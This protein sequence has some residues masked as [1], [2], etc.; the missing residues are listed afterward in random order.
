MKRSIKNLCIGLQLFA[1][2]GCASFGSDGDLP[3]KQGSH[4]VLVGAYKIDVGDQVSVSVWKNPELSISEPVR[5]DGKIA[6]HLLGDIDAAGKTPEELA[7][8]IEVGLS[9]YIMD[10]NVT[11]ILT[12]LAGQAFLSRIRVTGAV[13]SNTSMTYHQG[14]TVLDAVLDAGSVSIYADANRTKLHRRT[15][16]GTETYNIRLKDILENG[17]MTTNVDL[18]PGD[19]IT[20][21]ESIF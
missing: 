19:V 12:G 13:G 5:P 11:V 9:N 14:M 17:D 18:A 15:E 21:P 20:V 16:S 3:D 8:D 6:V 2:A 1:L 4:G 10:P 7:K